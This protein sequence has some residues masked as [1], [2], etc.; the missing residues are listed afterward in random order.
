LNIRERSTSL[1]KLAHL[2]V[3]ISWAV[4][5]YVS[6]LD[7]DD[8]V[9]QAFVFLIRGFETSG[10]TLCYVLYELA[11]Y[12]D[13]QHKLRDE[14][15]GVMNTNKGELTYDGV[16]E[17]SYLDMVVSGEGTEAGYIIY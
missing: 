14:I 13:I 17:M 1:Y 5:F 12:L 9:A 16:Q 4:F 6:E 2:Y 11:L 8:F 7:G 15:V 3:E 10:N